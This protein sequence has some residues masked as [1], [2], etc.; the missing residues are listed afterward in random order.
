M[1]S[2]NVTILTAARSLH[3]HK[4]E[5]PNTE[6]FWTQVRMPLFSVRIIETFYRCRTGN[7]LCK[8]PSLEGMLLDD[9]APMHDFARQNQS[10]LAELAE[11]DPSTVSLWAASLLNTTWTKDG[12]VQQYLTYSVSTSRSASDSIANACQFI[13]RSPEFFDR[14]HSEMNAKI[15]EHRRLTCDLATSTVDVD[16][17]CSTWCFR[18]VAVGSTPATYSDHASMVHSW[19]VSRAVDFVISVML[20]LHRVLQVQEAPCQC[21]HGQ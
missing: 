1:T 7:L 8:A 15:P 12:S 13:L 10:G 16:D 17:K 20:Q 18:V 3:V 21:V 6:H 5:M 2:T 11:N 4:R 14:I 19:D 9:S